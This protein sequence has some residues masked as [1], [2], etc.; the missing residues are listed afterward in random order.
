MARVEILTVAGCPNVAPAVALV[1]RLAAELVVPLDL[2]VIEVSD[3]RDAQDRRFL[4]SPTVRVD[5]A[6]VEPG[7]SERTGFALA[8][9]VYRTPEGPSGL[10]AREWIRAALSP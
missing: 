4:G 9:R 6:D 3:P 5:G 7:A 10:P 2:N 1:E 8:C